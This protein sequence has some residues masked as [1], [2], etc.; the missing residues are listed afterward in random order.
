M[1]FIPTVPAPIRKSIVPNLPTFRLR[2]DVRRVPP[3][4]LSLQGA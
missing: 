3:L 1:V 2:V 4:E